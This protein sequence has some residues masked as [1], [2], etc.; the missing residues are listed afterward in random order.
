MGPLFF[1]PKFS[2]K[3]FLHM[4]VSKITYE[5]FPKKNFIYK[6]CHKN[7]CKNFPKKIYI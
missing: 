3:I 2:Q 4:G 6:G 1:D 7:R 5:N